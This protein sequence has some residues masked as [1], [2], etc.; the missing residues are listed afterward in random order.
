MANLDMLLIK[1]GLTKED[2]NTP[3]NDQILDM[4]F[5]DFRED[6]EW[7]CL[8]T[9]IGVADDIIHDIKIVKTASECNL[10]LALLKR[11]K[12]LYG[13]EATYFKLFEGL[14]TV[15]RRDLT[16]KVCRHILTERKNSMEQPDS[17]ITCWQRW[18]R[19]VLLCF[20]LLIM[21]FGLSLL[22]YALGSIAFTLIYDTYYSRA[23]LRVSE[24]SSIPDV[25]PDDNTTSTGGSGVLYKP[26][27]SSHDHNKSQCTTVNSDLPILLSDLFIGR[28]EDIEEIVKRVQNTLIVNINGAP[29]FG[30]STLAIHAGYK[31]VSNGTSVRYVDVEQELPLFETSM[32]SY[33]PRA[34]DDQ[35]GYHRKH[36]NKETT[37]VLQ[38]I[39]YVGGRYDFGQA[40]MAK[41][42]K[43]IE[44]VVLWS[45]RV[46]CFTVLILDNCDDIISN[47]LRDEFINLVYLLVES[48]DKYVHVVVVTQAKLR[49][50]DNF[51]QWTV[52]ELSTEASVQLLQKLAPGINS[53]QALAVSEFVE[54][55]PLALKVVGNILHI[56]GDTLT[57]KLEKELECNPI[58]VLD[59]VDL[60]KQQFRII[61]E[62]ALSRISELIS[63]ECGYTVSLFPGF[64]SWEAGLSILPQPKVCLDS[65]V[66]YSLLDEYYRGYL[67]R[68]KMHRLIREFLLEKLTFTAR[69]QFNNNF[70]N[71][72]EEF[73]LQYIEGGLHRLDSVEEYTLS[74]EIQ[75]IH[76][77]L[78][79]LLSQEDH[80]T[81]EQLAILSFAND[82]GWLEV[83]SLK[84]LFKTFM[85]N[86]KD[87]CSFLDND[88]VLCGSLYS[89]VIEHLYTECSCRN[90]SQYVRH[91]MN[92]RCPC[93]SANEVFQC[94]TAYDINRTESIWVHLSKPV[95]DYIER[96][97]LYNCYHNHVFAFSF[98]TV[99]V[100]SMA[101]VVLSATF[102][103]RLYLVAIYIFVSVIHTAC[104]VRNKVQTVVIVEIFLK[105]MC[106]NLLFLLLLCIVLFCSGIRKVVHMS[107]LTVILATFYVV[108][109]FLWNDTTYALQGCDFMPICY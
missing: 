107:V 53:S 23:D 5:N 28:D 89:H 54:R 3:V 42:A 15:G 68:Y 104:L 82:R 61:M 99:I 65:F 84:P 59:D 50:L 75:N 37:A 73:V 106:H 17:S 79:L 86:L 11:W 8:G 18:P 71:Y 78:G 58:G 7:E 91:L 95:K 13:S 44:E 70:S 52:K 24:Y 38:T 66:K 96:I 46:K 108:M 56:Y 34:P 101:S 12:Q 14:E 39:R 31:L 97:M 40:G 33:R 88:P 49:L 103:R 67:H 9:S 1:M 36:F 41:P 21:I 77:Y 47:E 102:K 105:K 55:C 74:L 93:T 100:L 6:W 63:Y 62:L 98:F 26:P 25:Y 81:P 51:D 69:G 29:G 57:Q 72:F 80:L 22:L 109:L 43:F 4:T 92:N 87:M 35:S 90:A 19:T 27:V 16:E 10:P 60:Q 64:F 83:Y 30:K 94:Q 85:E 45:K 48:S 20:A 76:Y 2:V 32:F